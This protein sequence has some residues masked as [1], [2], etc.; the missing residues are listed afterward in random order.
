MSRFQVVQDGKTA[1][2]RQKGRKCDLEV[3]LF[4]EKGLDRMPEVAND[5]HEALEERW[6]KGTG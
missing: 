5:R 2:Q 6:A 3:I 1:Y 4:G